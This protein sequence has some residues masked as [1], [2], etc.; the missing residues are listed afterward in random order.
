MAIRTNRDAFITEALTCDAKKSQLEQELI[1]AREQLIAKQTEREA[2]LSELESTAT[3]DGEIQALKKSIVDMEQR[4]FVADKYK[5]SKLAALLDDFVAEADAERAEHKAV[6]D[7][8]MSVIH[9]KRAELLREIAKL[10]EIEDQAQ[11]ALLEM[12]K[13][14][15]DS[16]MDAN[17][18][19]RS[20][21]ITPSLTQDFAW[22]N[23]DEGQLAS[24]TVAVPAYLVQQAIK[25]NLP[26]WAKE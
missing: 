12:F 11:P 10:K 23:V 17:N 9:G 2:L 21:F 7:A 5:E 22:S 16:G 15:R 24:V 25:G 18:Y 1:S 3:I 26:D 4:L 6:F 19:R 20:S 14:I 13:A 8:Q